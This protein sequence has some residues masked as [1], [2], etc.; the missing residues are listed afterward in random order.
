[1]KVTVK[2]ASLEGPTLNGLVSHPFGRIFCTV[3]S[4]TLNARLVRVSPYV[5]TSFSCAEAVGI[6]TS[7]MKAPTKNV[8]LSIGFPPSKRLMLNDPST[9]VN[10]LSLARLVSPKTIEPFELQ[11]SV[12]TWL[13]SLS[14]ARLGRAGLMSLLPQLG[15]NRPCR[16][17]FPNYLSKRLIDPVL[18]AWSGFLK[19]IKNVSVNSQRDKLLGIR[20]SR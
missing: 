9:Y 8:L 16:D 1:M 12:P 5:P 2:L 4:D 15:V 18:P 6:A 10:R 13:N 19:M 14:M 3:A 11:F 7:A 20:D 17:L